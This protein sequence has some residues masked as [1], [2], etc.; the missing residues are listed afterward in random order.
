MFICVL[1]WCVTDEAPIRTA[2]IFVIWSISKKVRFVRVKHPCSSTTD[3]SKMVSLLLFIFLCA[4]VVHMWRF[5]CHHF[6]LTAPSFVDSWSWHFLDIFTYILTFHITKT[7][8][9]NFDLLKPHFCI[10]KLGVTGVLIM[11]EP[12]R[13]GGSNEYPQSMFFE[14]VLTSTH[15]LCFWGEI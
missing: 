14:A 6:F 2:H 10:V 15:N 9:Y 5:F 1:E 3:G 4:S 11:W 7:C 13:R 8:V 12:P